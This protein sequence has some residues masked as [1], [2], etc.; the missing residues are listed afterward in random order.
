[1]LFRSLG[2]ILYFIF[3]FFIYWFKLSVN[4]D[5]CVPNDDLVPELILRAK[6]GIKVNISSRA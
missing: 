3:I 1:M 2:A 5:Y 4:P 6:N